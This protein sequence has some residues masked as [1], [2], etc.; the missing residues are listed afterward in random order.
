M[1]TAHINGMNLNYEVHGEGFPLLL[2]HG[3]CASID[4]WR[5]QIPAFSQRYQVIAYDARG[6]GLS[7]APQ[8]KENYSLN[9]LVEDMHGML[10][11]LGIKEAYLAGHSMGGAT[12]AA[13]A[14]RFPKQVKATLI[15]NID[16]GHQP[17]DA[18]AE[19][20]AQ[21]DR[22]EKHTFVRNFGLADYARQQLDTGAAPKFVR[23]NQKEHA[24]FIER[25]ARQSEN[26]Y[27]GV[28]DA[29]PWREASLANAAASLQ[30][31][32]LIMAG[33]EDGMHL[34]AEKLHERLGQSRFVSISDA[35]HDSV[36]A[37]PQAFENALLD[38]LS[39][40]EA[41]KTL[42]GKVVV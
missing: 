40:L 13:Y 15:C 18:A 11:H 2:A 3:Y 30:G 27:F 41:G 17:A 22:K 35:P 7:S 33:T 14:E 37:R 5:Q 10:A 6:H 42:P 38:Y 23:D 21:V 26:G 32:V 24:P 12:V 28:G 4:M 9:H 16:A 31:P 34:G 8:G 19:A 36:N 25:Y 29:L 39:A 1:P 20:N